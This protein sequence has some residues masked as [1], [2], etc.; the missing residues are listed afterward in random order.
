MSCYLKHSKGALKR[1]KFNNKPRQARETVQIWNIR[2]L[3]LLSTTTLY[4]LHGEKILDSLI[5]SQNFVLVFSI[6]SVV[7]YRLFVC[8]YLWFFFIKLYYFSLHSRILDFYNNRYYIANLCNK[9]CR[10]H[11]LYFWKYKLIKVVHDFFRCKNLYWKLIYI[12]LI[13]YL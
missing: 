1:K 8:T 12:D 10:D 9:C 5:M 13:I 4:I 7:Y 2:V 6:D 3:L 11:W